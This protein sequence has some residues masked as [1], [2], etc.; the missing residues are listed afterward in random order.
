MCVIEARDA[1][2]AT[3]HL[4]AGRSVDFVFGHRAAR[5]DERPRILRRDSAP[6]SPT[7][8]PRDFGPILT[9]ERDVLLFVSQSPNICVNAGSKLWRPEIQ[10]KLF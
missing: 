2:Q 9:V 5:H 4:G 1:D 7:Q 6:I 3:E 8:V 10:T